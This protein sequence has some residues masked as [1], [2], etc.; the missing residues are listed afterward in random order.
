MLT[1][2]YGTNDCQYLK[3][4][5]PVESTPN[6]ASPVCF[7]VHG[8]YWKNQWS[9]DTALLHGEQGIAEFMTKKGYVAVEIE[10]RRRDHEGGGYR[11]TN[12]DVLNAY[13]HL[14]KIDLSTETFSM[15]LGRVCTI[16]HSAGG[17]LVLWLNSKLVQMKQ[18]PLPAL[19]VA[20]AP[21]TDLVRGFKERISDEGDAVPLYMKCEPTTPENVA[22]YEEASPISQLEYIVQIPQIVVIGDA[23]KNVPPLMVTDY[24]VEVGKCV[25]A[26]GQTATP[27]ELIELAGGDH[28][29]PMNASHKD[30]LRMYE[31]MEKMMAGT[32]KPNQSS[33]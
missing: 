30:F 14:S 21:V 31:S 23:D 29:T 11:G 9:V 2:P 18:S 22:K 32:W 24:F 12:E 6:V 15:D 7:I 4:Y 3:L 10:Y 8:G 1:I 5:P 13:L 33:I 28:F 27:V 16:G 20:V 19:T 17:Q 26:S 25:T